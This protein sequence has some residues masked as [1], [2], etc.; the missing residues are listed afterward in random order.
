MLNMWI[1]L[2]SERT[3]ILGTPYSTF[4]NVS[5]ILTAVDIRR[6]ICIYTDDKPIK[7]DYVDSDSLTGS[8]LLLAPCHRYQQMIHACLQ[9]N[10]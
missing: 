8:C 2:C 4:T 10:V 3:F 9:R 1:M 6:I 5:Y 7:F